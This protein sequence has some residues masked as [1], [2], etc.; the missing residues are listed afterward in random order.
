MLVGKVSV[1]AGWPFIFLSLVDK[2]SVPAGEPFFTVSKSQR[3]SRRHS[4]F[5]LFATRMYSWCIAP[6]STMKLQHGNK[7]KINMMRAAQQQQHSGRSIF[8]CCVF[9]KFKHNS[10]AAAAA[11]V[12]AT[13]DFSLVRVLKTKE[14][15]SVFYLLRNTQKREH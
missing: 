5:F 4:W 11:T 7:S 1:P 8:L 3:H 12:V 2:A 9:S 15:N 13:A 10:A 6:N 14:N